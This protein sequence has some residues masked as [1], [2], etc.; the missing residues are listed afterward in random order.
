MRG[1]KRARGSRRDG[2]IAV[3]VSLGIR[4]IANQI[5]VRPPKS[6]HD[7]STDSF[8]ITGYDIREEL[9][10]LHR[11]STHD[12]GSSR[13]IDPQYRFAIKPTLRVRNADCTAPSTSPPASSTPP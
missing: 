1:L 2:P 5:G 11:R 3:S 4:A 7:R 9:R 13:V 10:R 6:R 8:D 12:A